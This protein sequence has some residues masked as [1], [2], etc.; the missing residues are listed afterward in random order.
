MMNRRNLLIGCMLA[1]CCAQAA[2]AGFD[3][4]DAATEVRRVTVDNT[5]THDGDS[6][7]GSGFSHDASQ[8]APATSSSSADAPR[9]N[10][11]NHAPRARRTNL[12]W[13]SLLP[14][15]IQ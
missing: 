15:S 2:A 10:G 14:G 8:T 4:P 1:L 11:S 12:G 13:Q 3:T 7:D 6:G 5:I 9:G